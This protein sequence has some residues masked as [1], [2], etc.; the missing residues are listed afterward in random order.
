MVGVWFM[1]LDNSLFVNKALK[2]EMPRARHLLALSNAMLIE[3]MKAA[4]HVLII[5]AYYDIAFLHTLFEPKGTLLNKN[6]TMIFARPAP[7]ALPEQV[8]EL[9]KF[10]RALGARGKSKARVNVAVADGGRFLHTKLYQFRRGKWMRT[11][12]GSANATSNGFDRNDEIFIEIQGRSAGIDQY[13]GRTLATACN[14]ENVVVSTNEQYTSFQSLLRD[15]YIY[16]KPSRSVPY[17]LNCFDNDPERVAAL[18]RA[19]AGNPLP[20]HEGQ[21][22]GMLNVLRLL[23]IKDGDR[24][25]KQDVAQRVQIIP[26]SIETAFGYWVPSAYQRRLEERLDITAGK[27]TKALLACGRQLAVKNDD[28]V[29]EVARTKYVSVINDR[30]ASV[31][32]RRLNDI[33]VREINDQIL[34]RIKS[35]REKAGQ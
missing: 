22:V 27:K 32:A 3:R 4:E 18:Q 31:S 10:Q 16:F 19:V 20:F 14:C 34:R 28:E 23:K 11:L 8:V 7:P 24:A 30:L 6:I 35:L 13:I 33:E 17:T 29:I 9:R 5:S 15:G 25:T 12:V 2:G 1:K 26:F 21:S